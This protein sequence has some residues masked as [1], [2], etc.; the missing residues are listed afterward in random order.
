MLDTPFTEGDDFIE[1]SVA[2]RR[3]VD[4][5][6]LFSGRDIPGTTFERSA[7]SVAGICVYLDIL[8]DMSDHPEALGRCTVIPGRI[9][10]AGRSYEHAEDIS[11]FD[12]AGMD[13]RHGKGRGE[14]PNPLSSPS[15]L[16]S[17][18]DSVSLAAQPAVNCLQ[19]GLLARHTSHG[20]VLLGPAMLTKGMLEA[21]GLIRCKHSSHRISKRRLS[22]ETSPR[23][24]KVDDG[25]PIWEFHGSLLSQMVAYSRIQD[26]DY[27]VLWRHQE[28]QPCCIAAASAE[29]PTLIIL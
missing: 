4:A 18:Y 1:E 19:V 29:K 3:L 5:A 21:S 16:I 8:T 25:H 17:G 6:R 15:D 26:L 2:V 7:L 12:L 20:S 22:T 9:E 14:A 28:C 13:Y 10:M 24:L 27:H 23:Q 11:D